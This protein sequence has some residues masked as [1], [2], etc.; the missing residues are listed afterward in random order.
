M[1]AERLDGQA[2][3]QFHYHATSPAGMPL[4]DFERDLAEIARLSKDY[5]APADKIEVRFD[6]NTRDYR[7][8]VSGVGEFGMRPLFHEQL[9][10][11]AHVPVK[12]YDRARE[13]P[14][15]F[16]PLLNRLI[17]DDWGSDAMVRTLAG[18]ARSLLSASYRRIDN[19]PI[20]STTLQALK[21]SGREF[22]V[23][24][25]NLSETRMTMKFV[26]P[27]VRQ[28]L[29]VGD[30]VESGVLITN[31]EV[32]QG[33]F[34]VSPFVH[35]LKCLNGL[36]VN[37]S[38][39][40]R[41]HVGR[42]A[43]DGDDAKEV[44][45]SETLKADDT[46]LMLKVRDLILATADDAHFETVVVKL[47]EARGEKIVGHPEKV[48]E[49]LGAA[50]QLPVDTQGSVLRNLVDQ[51]DGMTRFG[52]LNAVTLAAQQVSTYDRATE[53]ETVGGQ[54]LDLSPQ[55]WREISTAK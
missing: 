24:S 10:T 13:Y 54:I 23:K 17:H 11:R 22:Q 46:A 53:L 44:F 15:E 30:I 2:G 21:S 1:N 14:R 26:F 5:V 25:V 48:V 51:G 7:L 27:G 3:I 42:S 18:D 41:R 19:Y 8:D 39:L 34:S 29:A 35:R 40:K 47:R 36:V 31:S 49:A 38:R 43:L 6:H 55:A 45:S 37:A 50:F 33:S 16:V 52:I 12:F 28:D 32:G 4:G 9:A 20:A